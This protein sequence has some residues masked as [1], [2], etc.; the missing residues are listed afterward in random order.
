MAIPY[1]DDAERN[2][3]DDDSIYSSEEEWEDRES[4][5]IPSP[6]R[7]SPNNQEFH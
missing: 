7:V 4:A 2:S 5:D 1:Y 6:P 3:V